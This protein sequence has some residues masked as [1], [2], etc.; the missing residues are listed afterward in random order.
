MQ[1]ADYRQRAL[2]GRGTGSRLRKDEG[3][4]RTPLPVLGLDVVFK[5]LRALQCDQ[6]RKTESQC[7]CKTLDSMVI[8]WKNR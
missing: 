1:E 8:D 2:Q 7:T 4:R 6:V 5:L 3:T